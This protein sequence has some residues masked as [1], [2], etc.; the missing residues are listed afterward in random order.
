MNIV[1]NRFEIWPGSPRNFATEPAMWDDFRR[2]CAE[3]LAATDDFEFT[4][5]FDSNVIPS[6]QILY[7]SGSFIGVYAYGDGRVLFFDSIGYGWS[8]GTL[9]TVATAGACHTVLL[10]S[11]SGVGRLYWDGAQVG[12]KNRNAS[13]FDLSI[14]PRSNFDGTCKIKF[15]NLSTGQTLWSYP[16]ESERLRLIT[17]TNVLNTGTHW[18][19]ANTSI[20]ARQIKTLLDLRNN[21]TDKTFVCSA[22]IPAQVYPAAGSTGNFYFVRQGD[23]FTQGSRVFGFGAAYNSSGVL[24]MR[25]RTGDVGAFIDLD[26]SDRIGVKSTYAAVISFQLKTLSLYVDGVLRLS[27]I[28]PAGSWGP[29]STSADENVVVFASNGGYGG[30]FTMGET[31]IFDRAFSAEEIAYLSK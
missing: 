13:I 1:D 7:S 2:W 10:A 8:G 6:G 27:Y 17:N 26:I 22:T 25:F 30:I 23:F 24:Q 28:I 31:L 21:T 18:E 29:G 19:A 4:L 5:K 14:P 20:V 9:T 3:N 15:V 12:Q 11:V 16:S